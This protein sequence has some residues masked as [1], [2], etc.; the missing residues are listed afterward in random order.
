MMLSIMGLRRGPPSMVDLALAAPGQ[1]YVLPWNMLPVS[2]RG[3]PV[4]LPQDDK[5]KAEPMVTT[6]SSRNEEK[7]EKEKEVLWRLQ[8]KSA[9]LAPAAEDA[10]SRTAALKGWLEVAKRL[11]P[12]TA[13]GRS[14]KSIT[15]EV[16]LADRCTWCRSRRAR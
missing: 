5:A 7:D 12:T 4:P 16:A 3:P 6:E 8:K 10:L 13:F 9:R 14:C 15:D 1:A 11:G 2:W